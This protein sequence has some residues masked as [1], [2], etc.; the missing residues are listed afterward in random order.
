MAAGSKRSI[1]QALA[2]AVTFRQ[3]ETRRTELMARLAESRLRTTR[4]RVRPEA[5]IEELRALRGQYIDGAVAA[6]ATL[7]TMIA[8]LRAAS[9]GVAP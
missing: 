6:E 4:S 9:R 8:R 5:F 1:R 3:L 7:D 2:A